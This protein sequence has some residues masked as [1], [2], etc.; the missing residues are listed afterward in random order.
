MGSSLM[1]DRLQL[2]PEALQELRLPQP[3]S[4][5]QTGKPTW[6]QISAHNQ[7][8]L[9]SS[10]CS[11]I[12][13]LPLST[14]RKVAVR[15]VHIA[16][17]AA[18][19]VDRPVGIQFRS[20]ANTCTYNTRRTRR[21]SILFVWNS[22][23]LLMSSLASKQAREHQ[24]LLIIRSRRQVNQVNGGQAGL[25]TGSTRC[26]PILLMTLVRVSS[27][28]SQNHRLSEANASNYQ[29]AGLDASSRA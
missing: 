14:I 22:L 10:R 4:S 8:E 18:Q 13:N 1:L 29:R 5:G 17:V 26:N 28:E 21:E 27:L 6:S 19:A 11:F 2:I 15:V 3:E 23:S 20:I 16:L 12:T 7:F 24:A 9:F 25:Q